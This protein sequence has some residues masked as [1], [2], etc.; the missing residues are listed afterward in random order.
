MK[1]WGTRT[2]KRKEEQSPLRVFSPSPMEMEGPKVPGGKDD[3]SHRK[4]KNRPEAV[5]VAMA[6][7]Q[8]V[9]IYLNGAQWRFPLS[10][11]WMRREGKHRH[12]RIRDVGL[13]GVEQTDETHDT[14][15]RPRVAR[16]PF[17]CLPSICCF[18]A[19][20]PPLLFVDN[21]QSH[22]KQLAIA[23]PWFLDTSTPYFSPGPSRCPGPASSFSHPNSPDDPF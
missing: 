11:A 4:R 20:P 2:V 21:K 18:R 13:P 10:P 3:R 19:I 1:L 6:E 23:A 16:R 5:V 15:G 7:P 14:G 9:G 12:R 8:S 17:L 22:S